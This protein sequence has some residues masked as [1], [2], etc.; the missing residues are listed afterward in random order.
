MASGP[1]AREGDRRVLRDRGDAP[2]ALLPVGGRRKLPN[3]KNYYGTLSKR[4]AA[5][6]REGTFPDLLDRTSRI[7]QHE[8]FS[9]PDEAR[10]YLRDIYR[11]DRTEG[12]EWTIHLGVEKDGLSLQLDSWFTDPLG[13]P[14]VALGGF[15]SQSLATAVR[16]NVI[17]QDRSAVLIYA[18]DFDPTGEDIPPR[19]R[20][21]LRRLRQGGPRALLPEQVREYHLPKNSD[22]KVQ[23]KIERDPRAPA[24]RERHG[25][26]F[27]IEV[28][29]LA[30]DV[31]RGLYQAAIDDFW[32]EDAYRSAFDREDLERDQL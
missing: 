1:G 3:T 5:A 17:A 24:F 16:R 28:D 25:S 10:D 23:E 22:P 9:G 13:I 2:P 27:Q 6:R 21:T 19:L 12:Q 14:H 30:P 32:D 11:R 8:F 7:E 26:V 15:A 29:A 31:L 4:T 20:E 18:G